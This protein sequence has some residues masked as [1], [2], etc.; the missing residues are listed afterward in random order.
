[1]MKWHD[2]A[3]TRKEIG[4]GYE[5]QFENEIRCHCGGSFS[6]IGSQQAG[7][8]D[9][10]CDNCGQLVD[11]KS[12]PQAERTGNIAVSAIPWSHYPDDMLL[13]AYVKG[14]W[15]GEYK[16]NITVKNKNPF[17]PTHRSNN[18]NLKNTDFHL[19]SWRQFRDIR[20]MKYSIVQIGD[21]E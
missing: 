16:Q 5:R 7:F 3:N 6:F 10:T 11:V 1:M 13:V 14:R 2:D 21:T 9:F 15:I 17:A 19:V 20:D 18:S 8:P 12:S 4:A